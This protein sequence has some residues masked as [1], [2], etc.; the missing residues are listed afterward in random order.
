[1]PTLGAAIGSDPATGDSFPPARIKHHTGLRP[2]RAGGWVSR[3]PRRAVAAA[4][5]RPLSSP[6]TTNQPAPLLHRPRRVPAP[7][8]TPS[9]AHGRSGWRAAPAGNGPGPSAQPVEQ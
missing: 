3:P 4:Y 5:S 2:P 9:C 1:M 8:G 6:S 7:A